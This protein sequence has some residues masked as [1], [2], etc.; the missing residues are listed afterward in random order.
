METQGCE[1]VLYK[2]DKDWAGEEEM[3][4]DVQIW[5]GTEPRRRDEMRWQW[6][7]RR[8]ETIDL[9]ER[10]LATGW[11]SEMELNDR[12]RADCKGLG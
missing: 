8:T 6:R 7:W 1:D 10:T 9:I 5:E 4:E 3:E 2:W 11:C 12:P